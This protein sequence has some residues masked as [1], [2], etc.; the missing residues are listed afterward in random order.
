MNQTFYLQLLASFLIGGGLTSFLSFLAEK[1]PKKWSGIIITFPTTAAIGFFFMGLTISPR[2]TAEII[3]S[4][5]ISLGLTMLFAVTY[6][7]AA[8]IISKK[9]ED[10]KLQVV[11]TLAIMV[12]LWFILSLIVVLNKFNNL[13]INFIICL[14]IIGISFYITT[15]NNTERTHALTYTTSQKIWRAIIVGLVIMSVIFF[16]KILNPFWGGMLTLF[17]AAFCSMLSIFHWKYNA[18]ELFPIVKKI[19]IGSFSMIAYLLGV[20]YSFPI[21]GFIIGT[22]IAYICSLCVTLTLLKIQR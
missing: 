18:D 11:C 9:I 4:T 1:A 20:M 5:L 10:K 14:A 15:L 7:Y 13:P 8:Q 6:P 12:L 21:F 3:P 17:P 22:I 2:N 16:S 19:P